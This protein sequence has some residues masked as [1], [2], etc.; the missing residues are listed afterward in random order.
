MTEHNLYMNSTPKI[1]LLIFILI[2]L[3]L[4]IQAQDKKFE[5]SPN[6]GLVLNHEEIGLYFQDFTY[7]GHLGVNIYKA[8]VK[9]F[10]SELQL[11]IASSGSGITSN[12]LITINGLYGGRYYILNPNKPTKVFVNILL[13]GAFVNETGDDFTE[14]LLYVGYSLGG[15]IDLNRLIVGASIESFN[16]IIFKIGYTF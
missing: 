8:R 12:N 13:G 5:F 14:S 2:F 15:Y 11:S 3:G 1:C 9:R 4:T 6:V 16:N 10:K 7:G